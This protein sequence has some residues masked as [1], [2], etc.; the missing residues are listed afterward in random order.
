MGQMD[1][2]VHPLMQVRPVKKRTLLVVSA[3]K[4]L[5]GAYNTNLL[6]TAAEA[7]RSFPPEDELTL[8]TLG[9]KAHRYFLKRGF[10]IAEHQE[11]W[12]ADYGFACRIAAR[13]IEHYVSGEADEV[14]C[15]Y[16]Q[17]VSAMV[18]K[19]VVERL[20]PLAGVKQ[21]KASVPYIF[22]PSP[23]EALDI[24]LPQFVEV[25]IFQLLLEGRASE[26]GARLRAMTNATDNAEKLAQDL[27]LEFF[28]ARQDTITREIIEVASGAE[29]LK[30][31]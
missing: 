20:L 5:C 15:A 10:S 23:Q 14:V 11:N 9:Q 8:V 13:I 25:R 19:P 3:D 29:S 28:R 7:A 6:R 12:P 2:A 1:E 30:R 31:S 24:I 18:Q 17:A 27:T 26:M 22:E 21:K 16:G 4:G